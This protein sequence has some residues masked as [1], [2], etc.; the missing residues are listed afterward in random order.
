MKANILM[1][2]L[3]M[4]SSMKAAI[5]LAP[6]HSKNLVVYKNMNFEEIQNLFCVTHK[7]LSEHSEEIL[8]VKPIE[9]TNPSWT[10]SR[11]LLSHD[12]VIKW[13]KAKVFVYSDSVL[14][15][16]KM[17]NPSEANERWKGQVADFQLS[18]SLQNCWELTENQ[19]TVKGNE[20]NCISNFDKVKT[21]AQRF[22]QG[23]W[24]FFD[25]RD[26]KKW[27]GNRNYK[28]ERKWDSV[29]SKMVQRFKDTGHPFFTG[30]SALSRGILKRLKG[31]E[32]ININADAS[33]TELFFRIIHSANQLSI[34][35]AV[36]QW[37]E[38]FDLNRGEREP[39]S[40]E[41]AEKGE[42]VDKEALNTVNQEVLKRM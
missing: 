18:D 1:W 26:E 6:D 28:P 10:R 22:S 13:T 16:S 7:L 9:S 25:P 8:Y 3:F 30:A 11:S 2:G 33:N 24:T 12:Q 40:E 20:G 39:H 27:Y 4:S 17:L 41:V 29:A 19:L 42:T 35:G 34:Y 23:R 21:Y 15:L 38:Q 14:C 36:S 5:H 32:N 37:S 31:K